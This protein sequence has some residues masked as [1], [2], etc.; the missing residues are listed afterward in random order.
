MSYDRPIRALMRLAAHYVTLPCSVC[1]LLVRLR[2]HY[3]KV[4]HSPVRAHIVGVTGTD[5]HHIK[6]SGAAALFWELPPA[7]S[8]VP[9][10][11]A[12]GE[13]NVDEDTAAFRAAA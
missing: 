1:D 11:T 2:E 4:E 9:S 13:P 5:Q 12:V 3:L 10:D 7:E 6:V 8:S